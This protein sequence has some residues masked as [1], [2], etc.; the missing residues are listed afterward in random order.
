MRHHRCPTLFV[1]AGVL[2]AV[3]ALAGAAEAAIT[4]WK[5]GLVG[6]V[7]D[8]GQA[9]QVNASHFTD[10]EI[11]PSPCSVLVEFFDGVTGGSLKTTRLTV[12]SGRTQSADLGVSESVPLRGKV[13]IYARVTI[14]DPNAHPACTRPSLEVFDK[15]S[16]RTVVTF[17]DPNLQPDPE[18]FFPALTLVTGQFLRLNAVNYGDP[19]EAPCPIRLTIFA[20]DGRVLGQQSPLVASGAGAFLDVGFEDPDQR[21]LV[22]AAASRV[23]EGRDQRSLCRAFVFSAEVYDAETG[24]TTILIG[25]PNT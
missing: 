16:G 2:A 9:V 11:A 21:V 12:P 3:L 24:I 18:A 1:A 7:F 5:F 8:A 14:G 25:D 10:P 17:E 20:A 4:Q 19:N 23:L 15:A 22:R 13:P 6:V